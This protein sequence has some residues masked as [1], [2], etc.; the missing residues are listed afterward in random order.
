MQSPPPPMPA[1]ELDPF[2]EL[3]IGELLLRPI[4]EADAEEIFPWTSDPA[5]SRFM[6][7]SAHRTLDESREFL[8]AA[9]AQA[10]ARKTLTWAVTRRGAIVGCVGLLDITFAAKAMRLDRG[11]L[12]YWTAPP[13][14]GQGVA[15][16]AARAV[17]TWAFEELGLHRI[18]VGCVADNEPSRK[19][20]EQLGFRFLCRTP[21][22]VFRDGRW[23]DV[24]RYA[25]R[26]VEW[27]ADEAAAVAAGATSGATG[28]AM[29]GAMS[30]AASA[31]PANGC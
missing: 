29:S 15:R 8:R 3:S 18:T 7:W 23:W 5:F 25:L 24:L 16:Q 13:A 17:M 28:D 2:V 4:R 11:E 27:R 30:G 6:S 14:Q 31:G 26:Q 20:I 21:E 1:P 12:G 10:A 22:E 19:V 9:E